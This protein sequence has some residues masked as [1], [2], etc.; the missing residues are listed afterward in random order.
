MGGSTF[1]CLTLS[2]N[3]QHFFQLKITCPVFHFLDLDGKV[4]NLSYVKIRLK[5]KTY[6]V[7]VSF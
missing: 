4:L 1:S 7:F 6:I 2:V 5:P 3:I